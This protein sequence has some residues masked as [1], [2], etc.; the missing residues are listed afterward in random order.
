MTI[1]RIQKCI[2]A[3]SLSVCAL[4]AL[5]AA[6]AWK[7]VPNESKL[8]FTA[9]QNDAPVTGEFKSFGGDIN[10]SPDNLDSSKI[11]IKVDLASVSASYGEIASTLKS[12]DWFNVKLFPEAVFTATHFTKIS[13][14]Y[15]QADGSLV[16]HDKSLPVVLNFVLDNF[17]DTKAHATG[18]TVLK[19]TAFGVGQGDWAK[20]DSVKDDVRVDFELSVVK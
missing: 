11:K 12:P 13:D 2:L 16:L 4:S 20:T 9:T 18:S 3:A 17:T 10:F 1:T 14:K 6:P 15:F 5:A 19:R 8:L 7:I